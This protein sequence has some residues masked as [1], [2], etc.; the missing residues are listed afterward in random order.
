MVTLLRG[1]FVTKMLLSSDATSYGVE[2]F[3]TLNY[4]ADNGYIDGGEVDLFL[5]DLLAAKNPDVSIKCRLSIGGR[6]GWIL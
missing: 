3:L 6:T 2:H 5:A 1:C 4:F